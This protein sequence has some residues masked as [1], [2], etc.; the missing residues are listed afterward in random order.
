MG[1]EGEGEPDEHQDS[2]APAK[3]PRIATPKRSAAAKSN[4]SSRGR[5]DEVVSNTRRRETEK[6]NQKSFSQMAE[7]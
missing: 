1:L 4:A 6:Y 5:K 3:R 7:S 2:E